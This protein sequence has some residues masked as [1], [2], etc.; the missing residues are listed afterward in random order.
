MKT[1]Y[2]LY[3]TMIRR[4]INPSNYKLLMTSCLLRLWLGKLSWE[5]KAHVY[6]IPG[7]VPIWPDVI[8][9][10]QDKRTWAFLC[11]HFLA[12]QALGGEMVTDSLMGNSYKTQTMKGFLEPVLASLTSWERDCVQEHGDISGAA[13]DVWSIFKWLSVSGFVASLWSFFKRCRLSEK[14]L[15]SL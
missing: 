10:F 11:K 14:C 4:V 6:G 1:Y 15:L 13:E 8:S 12:L 7:S 9:S 2:C 3:K 5:R